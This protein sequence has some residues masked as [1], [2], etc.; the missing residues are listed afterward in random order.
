MHEDIVTRG[1]TVAFNFHAV[2]ADP[3]TKTVRSS[4]GQ[5]IHYGHLIN[6]AGLESDRVAHLFGVGKEYVMMP[7]KGLYY[8]MYQIEVSKLGA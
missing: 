3:R 7:F 8:D 5:T 2:S 4:S 6:A 1:A